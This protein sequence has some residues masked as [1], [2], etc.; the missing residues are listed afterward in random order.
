[1][2]QT[3]KIQ[4]Q[5]TSETL[6][7]Q[8]NTTFMT[9]LLYNICNKSINEVKFYN[10]IYYV[11]LFKFGAQRLSRTLL[12]QQ[13]V[14]KVLTTHTYTHPSLNIHVDNSILPSAAFVPVPVDWRLQNL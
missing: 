13:K 14:F 6:S 10:A 8:I 11:Q 2:I 1:M 4:V 7:T 5:C 9:A 12:H 3:C